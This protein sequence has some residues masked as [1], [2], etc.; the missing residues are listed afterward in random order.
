MREPTGNSKGVGFARVDFKETCE[1]IIKELNG[2]T[3]PGKSHISFNSVRQKCLHINKL[4]SLFCEP[5]RP[6]R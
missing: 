2:Q 4:C 5:Q 3:F 1:K 6:R